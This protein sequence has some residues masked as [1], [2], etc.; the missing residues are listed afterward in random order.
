M[1]AGARGY[2]LKGAGESELL[3]VLHAAAAGE[4]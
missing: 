3:R 2:V 4:A 1:R